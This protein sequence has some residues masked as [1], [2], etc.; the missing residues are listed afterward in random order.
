MNKHGGYYGNKAVIDFSINI[1]PLGPSERVMERLKY[2]LKNID[3]YPEIDGETARKIISRKIKIDD[4]NIILANG[5]IQLIY[6]FSRTMKFKNISIIQPTF[7]EYERAFKLSNSNIEYFKTDDD[8][9]MIDL[10]RLKEHL[11]QKNIDCLVLCNPNNPTGIFYSS[12]FIKELL[13]ILKEENIFL[14][15]DESFIDFLE[16]KSAIEFINKYHIFILRS[17]TKFYALPGLRLGYGLAKK[18]IIDNLKSNIEPWSVNSLALDSVS[19]VINDDLYFYRTL[20]WLYVERDFLYKELKKIPYLHVYKTEINFFL[21]KLNQI[22]A[23]N[24]KS[25]LLEKGIYI[26]TCEDF[27]GLDDRYFRIAIK[28]QEEN[29]FLIESLKSLDEVGE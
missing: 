15:I 3:K 13:D 18:E 4:Q 24:L 26:R 8:N 7:N 28:K 11:N 10:K 27:I 1:N 22:K 2:S 9:F 5:A 19:S 29:I 21:C 6:T 16:E 23:Y 25:F 14:F 17:L 20:N 12:D